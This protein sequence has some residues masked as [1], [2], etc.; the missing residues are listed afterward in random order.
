MRS[1]RP[2]Q[3]NK[4]QDKKH[5]TARDEGHGPVAA[6]VIFVEGVLGHANTVRP[7]R[8]ARLANDEPYEP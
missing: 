4:D 1:C 5:G 2:R 8:G 7:A 3:D 6:F